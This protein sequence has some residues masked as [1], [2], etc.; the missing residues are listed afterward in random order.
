MKFSFTEVKA[1]SK[2]EELLPRS[3]H[4]ITYINGK[5]YLFGG[6][7]IPRTP[8]DSNVFALDVSNLGNGWNKVDVRNKD[9]VSIPCARLAHAQAAA[10]NDLYIYGG[11]LGVDMNDIALPDMYVFNTETLEW[12][13]PIVFATSDSPEPRSFHK[14]ISVNNKLYLFGGCGADGRLN[15]FWEYEIA[16]NTWTKL[17]SSPLICGRGGPSM[18][19]SSDNKRIFIA[20]GFSGNENNDIH[21]Y[22]IETKTWTQLAAN[23]DNKYR[24]RSVCASCTLSNVMVI[25][26]GEVNSSELGHAGAGDFDSKIVTITATS[27]SSCEVNTYD[28]ASEH[29]VPRGWNSMTAISDTKAILFGGLAGNDENPLRL[30]DTWLI[31]MIEN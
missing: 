24:A 25:V 2:T 13:G 18:T 14:M 19:A 4:E 29:F 7:N 10:G 15:D 27:N 6:E 5:V 1:V 8:I 31:E 12:K 21:V 11:R 16:S 30:N 17:P 28:N 22:D 3:S 23:S 26:G 20:T 9:A